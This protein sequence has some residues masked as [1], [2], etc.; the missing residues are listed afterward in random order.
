[1]AKCGLKV[2][3]KSKKLRTVLDA[4]AIGCSGK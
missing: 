3:V 1:M 2:K 4:F